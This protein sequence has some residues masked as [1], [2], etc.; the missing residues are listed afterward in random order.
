MG[1]SVLRYIFRP[2]TSMHDNFIHRL[3]SPAVGRSVRISSS[4]SPSITS[5][6]TVSMLSTTAASAAGFS[7]A[8]WCTIGIDRIDITEVQ[9]SHSIYF[10]QFDRNLLVELKYIFY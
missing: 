8:L 6:S 2:K 10:Q 4:V 9:P 1:R 5:V 7:A 3:I